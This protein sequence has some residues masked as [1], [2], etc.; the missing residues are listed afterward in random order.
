MTAH[1]GPIQRDIVAYL[2]RCGTGGGAICCL[3]RAQEFRGYCL[4]QV[5][6]ALERL[7]RRRL[8]KRVGIRYVLAQEGTGP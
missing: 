6:E 4:E 8:I 5:E 2:R 1:M 7:L 3:T